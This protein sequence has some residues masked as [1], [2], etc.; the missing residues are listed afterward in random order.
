MC[1]I[2][3]YIGKRNDAGHLV[4]VCLR[5]LEYRGYDS[6]GIGVL[7]KN[8][9]ALHKKVGKVSAPLNGYDP[10]ERMPGSIALGHTRWA[11]HGAPSI[12][13]AHPHTDKSGDI[14]VVHN[15]IVENNKKLKHALT[16]DLGNG[17]F[18]SE[19]DTEV[20]PHLFGFY[21]A[22]P[23]ATVPL[24]FMKALREIEGEFAVGA[25]V[26]GQRMLLWA[27]NG[28]PAVVGVGTDGYF[29]ASDVLA[30]LEHTNECFYLESGECAVLSGEAV[31][32]FR[33]ADGIPIEKTSI[34]VDVSKEQAM[35]GNYPHFMLKE[36]AE[37]AYLF[38]GIKA[39]SVPA[40]HGAAQELLAARNIVI[41]ACGTAAHMG[42]MAQYFFARIAKMKA[43]V[44]LSSEIDSEAPL[45]DDT[46]T[47]LAISQSGETADVRTAVRMA[48]EK[49][50]RIVSL[51]NV[52]GS[53]LER[54]SDLV[55]PTQA[56]MEIG[57]ASTKAAAAQMTILYLLAQRI[58]GLHSMKK[59]IRALED[60]YA[61][62]AE[63][64]SLD[65]LADIRVVAERILAQLALNRSDPE[66]NNGN[67][68]F[69]IGRGSLYPVALEIALKVKEIAYIHANGLAAGELKHGTLALME[70][71]TP[72][73]VLFGE[74]QSF[75]KTNSN[76]Q[77]MKARGAFLISMGE[78]TNGDFPLGI[79][80]P[81]RE[82]L[83][84]LGHM[85]AGQMLAY[86]LAVLRGNDP[87]KPRNLAKSV[88]VS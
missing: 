30:F 34:R 38:P 17:I 33:I 16:R 63:W 13:N 51:V 21:L 5:H 87:D 65:A 66:K 32:F 67:D 82:G 39:V 54:M 50:A 22:E 29:I 43:S 10:L 78:H 49:G 57:V 55:I 70:D 4:R 69:I 80:A 3:G 86:Q 35:L 31:V 74:E 60:Q 44:V 58:V 37:Q 53:S 76:A 68:M 27:T 40:I 11:T 88:T 62:I 28:P 14:A 42:Y 15:G 79:Y 24:A 85:I 59:A 1:G 36:I 52:R 12:I 26:R 77:E 48:K 23:G 6:F 8:G 18:R 61:Q 25:M 41:T 73:L 47:L 81:Y 7:G 2:A 75:A 19:T 46:T 45:I 20:I 72:S 9:I 83:P 56:G 84:P 71:Q 64:L